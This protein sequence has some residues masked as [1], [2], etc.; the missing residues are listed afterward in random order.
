MSEVPGADASAVVVGRITQIVEAAGPDGG[1]PWLF[2]RCL[3]HA[4]RYEASGRDGD[5]D[6]A[7]ADFQ[8]LPP[9]AP[10]RAK[11]AAVLAE[12]MLGSGT[13]FGSPRL[14]W[15]VALAD[16]ADADPEPMPQWP[17]TAAALRAGDLV[18]AAQE[19]RPGFD[20][21]AALR[22]L[23]EYAALVDGTPYAD[24]VD[25]AQLAV[26]HLLVQEDPS[27]SEARRVTDDMRR[28]TD[29]LGVPDPRRGED[30]PD[31][32]SPLSG[33]GEVMRL[34]QEMHACAVRSDFPAMA[35]RAGELRDLAQR[36]PPGDPLRG[37]LDQALATVGPFLGM[38]GVDGTGQGSAGGWTRPVGAEELS[39]FRDLAARPG[40][41]GVDR[42]FQLSQL[43]LAELSLDTPESVRDAIGHLTEALDCSPAHDPRRTYYRLQAGTAYL[44]QFERGDRRAL[45]TA[46]AL[47]EEA[48]DAAAST[49]HTMWTNI[50]MPLAYAYRLAD[51]RDLSRS[52]ALRGLRGH[53]WR[54]LLESTPD[55]VQATARNATEDALETARWCLSDNAAEDAAT[56]LDAG[57]GLILYAAAETRDLEA[58]LTAAGHAGL[59]GRWRAARAADP[60]GEAPVDLRRD[61][62]AALAGVPL[63]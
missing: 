53:A 61:V 31:G 16:V 35:E 18:V 25:A 49:A 5:I 8:A 30:R 21:R 1:A 26:R 42:A 3:A 54:V 4:A 36:L 39:V 9:D 23:E 46:T 10:G 24:A 43:A 48:R 7:L 41:S 55:E 33:P 32:R 51:R 47:L 60:A 29:R 57:R 56:A 37:Q 11:L 17:R 63:R 19:S 20:P 59:A 58:R 40:L 38:L 62:V 34:M 50:A 22:S 14:S 13:L 2:A 27:A 52:T 45:R 15:A 6:L 12:L 28:Y 44:R